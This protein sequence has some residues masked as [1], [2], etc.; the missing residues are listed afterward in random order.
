MPLLALLEYIQ[1]HGKSE[2]LETTKSNLLYGLVHS[3]RL[4]WFAVR[5][6]GAIPDQSKAMPRLFQTAFSLGHFC[7]AAQSAV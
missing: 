5:L 2:N 6:Y 4:P 7:A 1:S 3:R